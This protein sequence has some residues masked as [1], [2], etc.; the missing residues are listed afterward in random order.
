[1]RTRALQALHGAQSLAQAVGLLVIPALYSWQWQQQP[2]AATAAAVSSSGGVAEERAAQLGEGVT[3]GMG[4]GGGG[5]IAF[6][7]GGG[8][9]LLALWHAWR[10]HQEHGG[11]MMKQ[12]QQ[13]L[14][15]Q[16]AE[17]QVGSPC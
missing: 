4:A 6:G 12:Q 15:Q 10:I 7:C 1:M 9:N 14:G 17:R 13:G 5:P 11:G 8:L 16:R 2:A 3:M